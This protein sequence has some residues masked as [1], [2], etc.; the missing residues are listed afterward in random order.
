MT[1]TN[2]SLLFTI[3]GD[4][5]SLAALPHASALAETLRS[6]LAV[7][8][9]APARRAGE[10]AR[11]VSAALEQVF[12]AGGPAVETVAPQELAA[13]LRRRAAGGECLVALAPTRR[14]GLARL[15]AGNNFEQLLHSG[16][17]PIVT[18]PRAG[19]P[20][21]IRRVLFPID[22]SPRSLPLFRDTLGLCRQL[23]A[24]LDLLHVFGDD[25]LPEAE[26]DMPRRLAA[27]SPQEL[28]RIDR[29][30]IDQLGAEAG[31]QGLRVTVST[32]EGRAHR[33]ILTY[34]CANQ[35]DLIVMA[36]HGA[37]TREDL[38]RG[39]TTARVMREADLPVLALRTGAA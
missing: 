22:L 38:L 37:R 34:A 24:A 36:S 33:E 18:L 25:R 2:R 9:V 11:R 6:P 29:D 4:T 10:Q 15:L 26:R 23:G 39:T 30:L 17:L 7:L 32:A 21:L 13:A 1:L 28:F 12:G 20:P 3:G 27:R 5:A 35:I 16:V 14:R 31:A 8:H 19:Q